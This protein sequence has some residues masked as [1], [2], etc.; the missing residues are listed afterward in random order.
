MWSTILIIGSHQVQKAILFGKCWGYSSL[1]VFY[2]RM[3]CE[4]SRNTSTPLVVLDSFYKLNCFLLIFYTLY[5]LHY[6]FLLLYSF[7]RGLCAF[8]WLRRRQK[9]HLRF[10]MGPLRVSLTSRLWDIHQ[11]GRI[12][13]SFLKW[14]RRTKEFEKHWY[15]QSLCRFR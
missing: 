9:C 12:T 3:I 15:I 13:N 1:C 14:D 11:W 8:I 2:E 6:V 10:T 7:F 5:C 4:K